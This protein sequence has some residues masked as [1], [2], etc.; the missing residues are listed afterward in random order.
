MRNSINESVTQDIE[1]YL[2]IFE[3]R[4]SCSAPLNLSLTMQ[5][6]LNQQFLIFS[7]I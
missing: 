7:S 2:C 6:L 3:I 1:V 4:E 5:V